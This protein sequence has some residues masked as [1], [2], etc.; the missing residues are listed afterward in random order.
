[1]PADE[2]DGARPD[3]FERAMSALYTVSTILL[4]A[5]IADVLTDGALMR[6]CGPAGVWCRRQAATVRE[7]LQRDRVWRQ[8][9]PA[10]V[11][12]AIETTMRAAEGEV[13]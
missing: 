9:A 10:V 12:E 3:G 7:R 5:Y 13:L 11:W 2:Y 6:A 4:C 1:M 8:E